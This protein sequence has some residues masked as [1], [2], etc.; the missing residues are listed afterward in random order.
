MQLTI[1]VPDRAVDEFGGTGPLEAWL[2]KQVVDRV[3]SDEQRRMQAAAIEEQR[4]A[5]AAL[6]ERLEGR[7]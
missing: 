3:V 1:T 2:S 6:R 5:L 4:V 7:A